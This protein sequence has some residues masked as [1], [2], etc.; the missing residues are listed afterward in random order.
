MVSLATPYLPPDRLRA[1]AAGLKLPV[2]IE[3]SALFADISGFT[4]VTER[5]RITLGARRGAEELA[6][7]LNKV[8][9]ALISQVERYGGSIIG[10]AGDAM[11]CWFSG[12]GSAMR[13]TACG[14]A[15]LE[16]IS[17]VEKITLP[18]GGQLLFGLKVAISSGTTKRFVVGDPGTQLLDAL[19]GTVVARMASG[20][21]LAERGE[22]LAD[23]PTIEQLKESVKVKEW[24]GSENERFAVVESL[25]I[26]LD[27]V[28]VD[29]DDLTL[30]DELLSPWILPALA[31]HIQA[32]L[33][34][35]QIELR[36][37]TALFLRFTG[38][39]YDEDPN[40]EDKLNQLVRLIQTIVNGYEGNVLQLT[41]GDKGSYLY[42]GFGAPFAH[43]DDSARTLNAAL[44]IREKVASLEYLDPIQIGISQGS[45]RT[46]AYGSKIRR[47]YSA[48]GD[49]VNLA[50]RLMARAAPGEILVS[51]TLSGDVRVGFIYEALPPI[52]VKGK[53]NPIGLFRLLEARDRSFA[54]RFYTTPMVGRDDAF[55]TLKNALQPIFESRHAGIIFVH[56]EPGMGKSRLAFEVQGQLQRDDQNV[57]W[58]TGQAD[59]L[60]RT[61]LSAFAYFLRPY[62]G[63]RRDHDRAANKTAFDAAFESVLAVAD[64]ANQADLNLYRSY[65]AGILGLII[66]GSPYETAE[67]R[68]Q[69]DN[70]IAAIKAWGRAEARRQPLILHLEDSHWLDTSSISAVQQLTYNME[71]LPLALLLTSR[72]KDDGSLYTI[73]NIHS[74]P[75]HSIDLNQLSDE[76][77]R[78]VAGAIL[79]GS[80][81]DSLARFIQQRAEGNPFFTEQ[82]ALDLKERS[83]LTQQGG[84]WTLRPES[85]AEVPSGINAV[86][87]ARLDRLTVQVKAVVQT[88]AVLGREFELEVL[89]RMLREADTTTIR[90]AER[91]AIWSALSELR[92]LFRHALLR[93][94]AYDMQA[95]ER[96]KALHR[97]AAETIEVLYPE[98]Q[99]QN[100]VLLEHW[101]VAD[102]PVKELH[103]LVP[104]C[105]RLIRSNADFARAERLLQQA[106]SRGEIPFRAVLLRLN[107]DL[108][109]LRG[110]Y[111]AATAQYESALAENGTDVIGRILT[112]FGLG[113]NHMMQGNNTQA[114]TLFE[115]GLGLARHNQHQ[116]H[117]ATGLNFLGLLAFRQGYNDTAQTHFVDSLQKY[118]EISHQV[119]IINVLNNMSMV[120]GIKG[121]HTTAYNYLEESLSLA[122]KM[123]NRLA[124]GNALYNLGTTALQ[125]GD[126]QT[127]RSHYEN[128][129]SMYREMGQRHGIGGVLGNLAIL[130]IRQGHLVDAKTYAEASLQ[131]RR[132]IGD[133]GGIANA[134]G[135]VASITREQN[136]FTT[137]QRYYED[138]LEMQRVVNDRWG[139][140]TTLI[141][142]G[143]GAGFEGRFT[144]AQAYLTEGMAL[145]RELDQPLGIAETLTF[146]GD[147]AYE[148]NDLTTARALYEEALNMQR[149]IDDQRGIP[150]SL[151]SLAYIDTRL[152][153]L[154]EAENQLIEALTLFREL[155]L[156]DLPRALAIMALVKRRLGQSGES[157]YPLLQEA[158]TL[159]Q[160]KNSLRS[161]LLTLIETAQVLFTD[162]RY[163]ILGELIGQ[164]LKHAISYRSRLNVDQLLDELRPYLDT[165]TLEAALERG[166]S[167]D[168]DGVVARLM[169]ELV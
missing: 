169:A 55:I 21:Q 23:T 157:V 120:A 61:P 62:F 150:I 1:I 167:L 66:P 94:A 58:L 81:S 46:G 76:G 38:I 149:G 36:P 92:Y 131:E 29:R 123:G 74:V 101:R 108:A 67:A 7:H 132:A 93:D 146:Q 48:L 129:L 114:A 22:L 17:V 40:A 60:N 28:A 163:I 113:S 5:L 27:L 47:T 142:L 13:A 72:Y 79:Q 14:C 112:L 80:I 43:E 117:V 90:D 116:N 41:I 42:I 139:I 144:E 151:M 133:K 77:V 136:D 54:E 110:Q 103:Y 25:E 15:L 70:G 141:N 39:D 31:S 138:V 20:E 18:D 84:E 155:D 137:A 134:L 26:P 95:Q 162:G 105:E 96:L 73:P 65:L 87:I 59:A 109:R 165:P 35:F 57:T 124:I 119:G 6:I 107:G 147:L 82:L 8:Y 130:E 156:A 51:E 143:Q 19:A 16:A 2:T 135:I 83:A 68:T 145:Y 160:G 168:L 10:F 64:E 34:E 11:T 99:T 104:V 30:S 164:I 85:A 118:R 111:E 50:A 166:K 91:E 53:A 128:T 32:G 24:R 97:L 9:D 12:E 71:N 122:R 45:M 140:A 75:V 88:A 63:Q 56:G 154:M 125:Q 4:P 49:E 78:T 153:M 3:G 86:L 69:I 89:S 126:Y 37:V 106:L 158:L 148:Q 33:G 100:D 98:D 121:H 102:D 161:T 152:G 44:D 52:V 159:E 127:A 115:Q